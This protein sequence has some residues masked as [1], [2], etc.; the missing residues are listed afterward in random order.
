MQ[1]STP[2]NLAF[3]VNRSMSVM[4]VKL[5]SEEDLNKVK[6]KFNEDVELVLDEAI[7]KHVRFLLFILYVAQYLIN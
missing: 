2:G 1:S 3:S 7:R 4:Y 5:L 6:D